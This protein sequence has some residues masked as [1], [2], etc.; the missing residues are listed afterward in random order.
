MGNKVNKR[1]EDKLKINDYNLVKIPKEYELL[2][3]ASYNINIRT[4][5]NISNRVKEI[6]SYIVTPFRNKHLDIISLQGINDYMALYKL[7]KELK[8]NA[9]QKRE[10]LYFAPSF[11]EI[12][13]TSD[14]KYLHSVDARS[15]RLRQSSITR[16]SKSELKREI[17]NIIVSR[18]PI[19]TTI[20]SELDDEIEIDE[21]LGTQTVMGANISICGNI[22]SVYCTLLCKDL[23]AANIIN[24]EVREKELIAL[25]RA[26]QKN[27]ESLNGLEFLQYVKSDVHLVSGTFNIIEKYDEMTQEFKHMIKQFKFVDIYRYM[28][29]DNGYTN[30]SKERIDYI[31]FPLTDDIYM[32]TSKY[33]KKFNKAKTP[34]EIIKFIFSRYKV[35]F[36]DA[37]VRE[38]LYARNSSANV[39]IEIVIMFYKNK[40]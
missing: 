24:V 9:R 11:D 13:S 33:H 39:P 18:Y 5:A 7:I 2:K 35:Y 22:I 6:V 34:D 14:S 31:F 38:D 19:V 15:T 16:S 20:Y 28:N 30:T 25:H 26:I 3:I 10:T 4:T 36:I 8:K 37:L 27:K 29:D 21:I 32:K 12:D 17:Q 1:R 40:H 23:K